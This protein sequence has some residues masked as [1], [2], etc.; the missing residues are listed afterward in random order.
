M[1]TPKVN[2]LSYLACDRLVLEL[3]RAYKEGKAAT[4][5]DPSRVVERG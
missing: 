5:G 4:I 3:S 2:C 1:S